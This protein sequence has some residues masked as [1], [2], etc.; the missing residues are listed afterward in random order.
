MI[1]G[2]AVAS[3]DGVLYQF[4][5]NEMRTTGSKYIWD[6]NSMSNITEAF[7][8]LKEKSADNVIPRYEIITHP[9]LHPNIKE[10]GL[11]HITFPLK[12]SYRYSYADMKHMLVI[13]YDSAAMGDLLKQLTTTRKSIYK[14]ILKMQRRDTSSYKGSQYYRSY[15]QSL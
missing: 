5:K 6:E 10:K 12:D 13:T 11:I 3:Q 8:P 2:I 14:G 15:F 9:M 4:D 1:V 7:A